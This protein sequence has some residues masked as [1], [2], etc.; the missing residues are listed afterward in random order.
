VIA[1]DPV[2]GFHLGSRSLRRFCGNLHSIGNF[3]RARPKQMA[4]HFDHACVAGLNRTQL[5]VVADL[6]NR[7]ASTVDQIDEELFGLGFMHNSVNRYVK[8]D[9]LPLSISIKFNR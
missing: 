2:E 9:V 5:R 1:Q 6:R 7:T 4:V 3:G 8:H